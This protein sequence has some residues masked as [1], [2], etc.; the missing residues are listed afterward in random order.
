M[1]FLVLIEILML[2]VKNYVVKDPSS[3]SSYSYLVA[4]GLPM[5]IV[6]LAA[7]DLI[8]EKYIAKF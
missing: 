2:F 7:S 8:Y 6:C 1:M 5:L 4:F 3:Y